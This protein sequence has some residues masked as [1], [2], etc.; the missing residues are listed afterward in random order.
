MELHVA[1][2]AGFPGPHQAVGRMSDR[3]TTLSS[4]TSRGTLS[5]FRFAARSAGAQK[6]EAPTGPHPS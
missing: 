2:L 1:T 6:A 3:S 5:R 4:G